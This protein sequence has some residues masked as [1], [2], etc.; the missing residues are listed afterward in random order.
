MIYSTFDHRNN[1]HAYLFTIILNYVNITIC[2]AWNFYISEL[3]DDLLIF[4][5]VNYRM[6]SKHY[7]IITRSNKTF[8][9]TTLSNDIN[10]L[11]ARV[12]EDQN[13]DILF[14]SNL[15][16]RGH[17]NQ[18]DHKVKAWLN[19]QSI[20]WMHQCCEHFMFV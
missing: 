17:I 12:Y 3:Q 16:F 13:L 9:C 2:T 19:N 18:I 7:T 5:L 14:T 10:L 1:F 4:T 20:I 15:K 8:D 6:C 11:I